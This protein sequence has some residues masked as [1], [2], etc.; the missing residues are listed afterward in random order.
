M[1]APS[2]WPG[3]Q[4]SLG[5][6]AAIFNKD[7]STRDGIFEPFLSDRRGASGAV[8][9]DPSSQQLRLTAEGGGRG[10]GLQTQHSSSSFL[11]AQYKFKKSQFFNPVTSNMQPGR[12]KSKNE[13]KLNERVQSYLICRTPKLGSSV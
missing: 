2:T 8:P 3:A 6:S 12:S 11:F 7:G 13:N 9:A 5:G 10:G 1:A 4:L